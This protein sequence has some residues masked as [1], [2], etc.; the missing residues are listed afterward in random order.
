VHY[1]LVMQPTKQ[2]YLCELQVRTIFEEGWSEV[3]HRIR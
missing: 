1:L 3:D 2:R